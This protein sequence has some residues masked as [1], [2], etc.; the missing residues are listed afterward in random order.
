MAKAKMNRQRERR[1]NEEVVVDAYGEDER[2]TSWFCYLQ[3]RLEFPFLARCIGTRAISPLR[4]GDEVDVIGMAPAPECEREIFV[5]IRW[6]Q[7]GLGVPLSQ[8]QPIAAEEQTAC[9]I[10]DWHYW[11]GR[12]YHF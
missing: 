3:D 6:E 9:T 7:D 8:L 10:D 12:G 11:I 1:I 2:A 4:I 5:M